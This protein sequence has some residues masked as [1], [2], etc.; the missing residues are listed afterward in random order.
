MYGSGGGVYDQDI[1]I[2]PDCD[3]RNIW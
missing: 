1:E 2:V 3:F